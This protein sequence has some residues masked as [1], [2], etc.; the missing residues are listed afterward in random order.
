[1]ERFRFALCLVG[2][3]VLSGCFDIENEWTLNPDGSG[4]VHH[5]V[6]HKPGFLGAFGKKAPRDFARE[7]MEKSEGIEAWSDFSYSKTKEGHLR[8]EGVAYFPDASAVR[9]QHEVVKTRFRKEG[10]EWVARFAADDGSGL[11][12]GV[13]QKAI[14]KSS[15]VKDLRSS[16]RLFRFQLIPMKSFLRGK[17]RVRLPGTLAPNHTGQ[18]KDGAVE[19]AFSF[20]RLTQ[21]L[22]RVEADPELLKVLWARASGAATSDPAKAKEFD[23][24]M[25]TFAV[26]GAVNEARSKGGEA[27]FD[28]AETVAAVRVAEAEAYFDVGYALPGPEGKALAAIELGSV[29]YVH[30]ESADET[31][32]AFSGTFKPHVHF[33][34]DGVLGEQPLKLLGGRL[35]RVIATD[36]TS[37]LLDQKARDLEFNEAGRLGFTFE[38]IA[39][40]TSSCAGGFEEVSGYV[41]YVLSSGK[42][43]DV[44]LGF[45]ALS[46]GAKGKR[47]GAVLGDVAERPVTLRLQGL[48]SSEIDNVR[49]VTAAGKEVDGQVSWERSLGHTGVFFKLGRGAVWPAKGKIIVTLYRDRTRHRVP[50][51]LVELDAQGVSRGN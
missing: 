34:F 41:E 6:I 45:A 36:G 37:L 42:T 15:S 5:V 1:M 24:L 7:L 10:S 3:L 33:H 38:A 40:L 26:G 49:I 43:R 20:E 16:L 4:K 22:D 17:E 46:K 35:T 9:L 21:F 14:G 32:F 11:D 44:D 13:M 48:D 28:Y 23:S 31:D 27:A 12:L 51:R 19:V 47:L 39:N 18:L 2:C 29:Q 30:E 50:F 25:T 8:F